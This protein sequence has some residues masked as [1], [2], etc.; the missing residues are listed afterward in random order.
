M[1]TVL[2][3]ATDDGAVIA[4]II[5][6]RLLL[7]LLIPR[8]PLVILAALV[9]DAIDGS[10]LD[11]LTSVDTGPNGPYQSFDKALD[12]YYLAIAYLST[13][14]NWTSPSAFRVGQF[15][16]YYRLV[17]VL[18]F[19]LLHSRAMLLIF[20]NTFEF[21][22]IAYE[23][24]RTRFDPQKWQK[25]FWVWVAAGLWIFVKL[26]QEYWIHIAQ[27]DFTEAVADHP[28]FGVACALGILALVAIALFVVRPRLRAPEWGWQFAAEPLGPAAD[29]RT[30]GL[31]RTGREVGAAR[32]D[33]GDLRRDPA[34][35]AG[36]AAR[37]RD[38]GRDRR[39]REHGAR[40]ALR[41]APRNDAGGL[42]GTA[43]D[44][45]RVRLPGQPAA[46]AQRDVPARH[47]PVL[48]PAADLADVAL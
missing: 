11:A 29:D 33:L 38:R 26:P 24:L 25:H 35:G 40:R 36:P 16:F 28:W 7:P 27:L 8:Y 2:A 41:P 43:G 47:R 12:I 22:F 48:R 30:H 9:L 46:L 3:V 4:A 37:H 17:G 21:F 31:A 32:P 13:L 42:R 44:Q 18:A 5:I 34:A 15:L 45:P 23:A 19:E 39:Q 10:L 1:S 14:R 20:P 6:S